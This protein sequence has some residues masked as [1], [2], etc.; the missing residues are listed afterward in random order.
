MGHASPGLLR[1]WYRHSHGTGRMR[2]A[3]RTPLAPAGAMR[4]EARVL[5][6]ATRRHHFCPFFLLFL[7]FWCVP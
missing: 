3:A 5:L 1:G 4:R 7:Q 2:V 6:G